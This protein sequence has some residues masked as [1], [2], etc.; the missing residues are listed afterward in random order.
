MTWEVSDLGATNDG[1]V[2]ICS[3]KR[4][5][6]DRKPVAH[7]LLQSEAKRSDRWK[8]ECAERDANASLIVRAVNAHEGLVKALEEALLVH[9]GDVRFGPDQL[10]PSW[11]PVARAALSLANEGVK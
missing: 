8:A 4:G 7:V 10:E 1:A 6:D 9:G 5:S 2:I 3:G 11:C